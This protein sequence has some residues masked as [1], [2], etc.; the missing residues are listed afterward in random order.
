MHFISHSCRFN[1]TSTYEFNNFVYAEWE[2]NVYVRNKNIKIDLHENLYEKYLSHD[3]FAHIN[4]P[5]SYA[6]QSQLT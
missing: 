4:Q 2:M 5:E 1:T 3:F 6:G